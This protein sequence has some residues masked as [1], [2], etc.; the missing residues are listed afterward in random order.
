MGRVNP[1]RQVYD[2][3]WTLLER[4]NGWSNLVRIGNRINYTDG[5]MPSKDKITSSDL[6]EVGIVPV[7]STPHFDAASNLML[8]VKRFALIVTTGERNIGCLVDVEFE[9]YRAMA[10]WHSALRALTWKDFRFCTKS[11][12]TDVAD[13]LIDRDRGI[14]GWVSVWGCEVYMAFPTTLLIGD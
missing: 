3:L 6:P 5:K 8:L 2:T 9:A 7:G 13:T 4:H 12:P 11:V 10:N 14:F 1:I